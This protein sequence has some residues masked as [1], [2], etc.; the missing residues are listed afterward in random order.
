MFFAEGET[1]VNAKYLQVKVHSPA[2][3]KPAPAP[4]A[5]EDQGN[6]RDTEHPAAANG[7][8]GGD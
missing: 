3:C 2:P 8:D 4:V 1:Q 7:R 5:F 6:K